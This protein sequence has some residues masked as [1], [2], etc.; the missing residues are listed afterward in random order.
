MKY[1]KYRNT[2]HGLLLVVFATFSPPLLGASAVIT[3]IDIKPTQSGD[4]LLITYR[5]HLSAII[6]SV[7]HEKHANLKLTQT[8]ISPQLT[9]KRRSGKLIK[10]LAIKPT[11]SKHSTIAISFQ[12]RLGRHSK[13]HRVDNGQKTL[14]IELLDEVSQ[15]KPPPMDQSVIQA[16]VE[17]GMFE[18]DGT[19]EKKTLDYSNDDRKKISTEEFLSLFGTKVVPRPNRITAATYTLNDESLKLTLT[20]HHRPRYALQSHK[21]PPGIELKIMQTLGDIEINHIE[22]QRDFI[23][24]L[25]SSR[26]ATNTLIIKSALYETAETSTKVVKNNAQAGY[27]LVFEIRRIYPWETEA[28][29]PKMGRY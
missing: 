5:G 2:A 12:R 24:D 29:I 26:T 11:T 28:A 25:I 19:K 16:V 10:S 27:Q 3:T 7:D 9:L 1:R 6:L 21:N 22:A 4:L 8:S 20:F 17:R 13:T 14:Q 18:L 23:G 15:I